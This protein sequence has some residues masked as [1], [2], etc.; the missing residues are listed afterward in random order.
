M[1]QVKKHTQ[2]QRIANLEKAVTNLY[3]LLSSLTNDKEQD[4]KE[5]GQSV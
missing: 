5:A 1:R 4:S 2:A 3:V